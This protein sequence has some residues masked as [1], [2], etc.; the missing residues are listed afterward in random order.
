M[1]SHKFPSHED[2][3]ICQNNRLD[4]E[5]VAP[6]DCRNGRQCVAD[7]FVAYIFQLSQLINVFMV[8]CG[9][10]LY[11]SRIFWNVCEKEVGVD[12]I[13]DMQTA[14]SHPLP[15]PSK[16]AILNFCSKQLCNA[17]NPVKKQFEIWLKILRILTKK[18]PE[19]ANFFLS[20]I[21]RNVLKKFTNPFSDF[22][23]RYGRFCT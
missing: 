1:P 8:Y 2:V 3:R 17:L 22:I 6:T 13:N 9:L 16:V 15:P 5:K 4:W 7:T 23:L 19:M 20:Q 10:K 18:R 11:F 21:M 12:P 14:P